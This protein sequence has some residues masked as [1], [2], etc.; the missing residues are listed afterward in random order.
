MTCESALLYLD[1]PGVLTTDAVES[2]TKAAKRFLALTYR[3]ISKYV[4]SSSSLKF[5]LQKQAVPFISK[6]TPEFI[7]DAGQCLGIWELFPDK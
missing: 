7:A 1:L 3:D 5:K 2:L 4:A 6:L